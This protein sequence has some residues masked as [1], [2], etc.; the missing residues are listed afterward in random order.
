M[1]R[2]SQ[3]AS[4]SVSVP[5]ELAGTAA[6]IPI[7]LLPTFSSLCVTITSSP[8]TS[9]A[10]LRPRWLTRQFQIASP[11]AA[12]TA[13]MAPSLPPEKIVRD[14]VDRGD[15]LVGVDRVGRAPFGRAHPDRACPLVLSKA[16]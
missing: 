7:S 14:A 6:T 12:F 5:F 16:T 15:E 4:L 3:R 13:C 11:L 10:V 2:T 9:A 1:P 8:T